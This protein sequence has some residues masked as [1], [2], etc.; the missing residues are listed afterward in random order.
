MVCVV[1]N[2]LTYCSLQIPGTL[3]NGGH[4]ENAWHF[5]MQ[6]EQH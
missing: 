2:L 1:I 3:P 5:A 6:S 4:Q